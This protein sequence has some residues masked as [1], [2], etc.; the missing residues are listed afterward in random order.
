MLPRDALRSSTEMRFSDDEEVDPVD[1]PLDDLGRHDFAAA[2]RLLAS[3]DE[4]EA[5][6][7]LKD[8][9]L[10]ERSAGAD[11]PGCASCAAGRKTNLIGLAG[12]TVSQE[13]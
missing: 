3:L 7:E 10:Q 12:F 2:D 4:S 1:E 13:T 8:R 11:G 5:E 9:F 6:E